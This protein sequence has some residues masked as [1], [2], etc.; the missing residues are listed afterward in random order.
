MSFGIFLGGEVEMVEGGA[1]EG[2][3]G[4]CSAG[5]VACGWG[6]SESSLLENEWTGDTL[7]RGFWIGWEGEL[8]SLEGG[9]RNLGPKGAW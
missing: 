5:I 8:E 1:P 2:A 7:G 9:K 6:E 4:A 3:T